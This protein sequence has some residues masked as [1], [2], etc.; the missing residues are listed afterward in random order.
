VIFVTVGAQMAF[1][2]L[3]KGVDEWAGERKRSDVFAQ[4]GPT[5]YRP[6][7]VEWT[8]FLEPAD[9]RQRVEEASAIVAHAGMG[10]ILTALTSGKPILVMPRRGDLR[11]TRNDHQVATAERFRALG[12]VAV[13]MDERELPERLDAIETLAASE[14]ISS[15]ASERLL[16]ALRGF[17]HEGNT[18]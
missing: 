6:S 14:P 5:D 1:D 10:S 15:Q 3:I 9:F 16:S 12:R 4:I 2:R 7:H 13:A 18:R 17:I 8:G 11:E